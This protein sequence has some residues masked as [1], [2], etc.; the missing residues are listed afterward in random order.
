MKNII[1]AGCLLGLGFAGLIAAEQELKKSSIPLDWQAFVTDRADL[2]V[3]K[4]QWGTL[5]WICSAKLSPGAA[6]T[7]GLAQ[8]YPGKT[9]VLHY[10]PN[11]EEVLHVLSG[12]GVQ[13]VDGR[14]I[15]LKP[16]MTIRIPAGARHQLAN[17]GFEPLMTVISFSAGDRQTVFLEDGGPANVPAKTDKSTPPVNR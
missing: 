3:E 10:H 8:V 11:C 2:P 9:N 14:L 15:Q 12:S 5:Q 6:Q 13:S 1:F 16:G 4:S 17:P 7:L